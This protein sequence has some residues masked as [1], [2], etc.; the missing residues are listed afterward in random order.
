[1]DV[2]IYRVFSLTWPASMQ[3][4]ETKES[5]RIRKEFNSQR[6]GL[7]HQHGRRFIVLEHQKDS[8]KALSFV[9]FVVFSKRSL[10]Y[11][12]FWQQK[13][14]NEKFISMLCFGHLAY[15][16]ELFRCKLSDMRPETIQHFLFPRFITYR[17]DLSKIKFNLSRER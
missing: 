17:D 9:H 5:V 7:G 8:N 15:N 13:K 4:I 2:D 3:V 1:M 10:F 14:R 16:S 6:I 12:P 11:L